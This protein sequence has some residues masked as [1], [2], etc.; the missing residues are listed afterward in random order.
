MREIAE[1][2][3]ISTERVVNILH[4]HL[5]IRKLSARWV[6][7]WITILRNHVKSQNSELNLVKVHQSVQTR[8]NRLGKLW[9]VFFGMHISDPRF[10][11]HRLVE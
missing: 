8:N 10:H 3:S 2:V 7:Q 5:C 4:T 6:L 11:I 9:L 1:I